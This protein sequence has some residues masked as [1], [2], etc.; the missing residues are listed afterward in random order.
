MITE[1]LK[2]F[3]QYEDDRTHGRPVWQDRGFLGL[4]V[5]FLAALAAKYAGVELDSEMQAALVVV[6][7]G[8]FHLSQPHVGLVKKPEAD[9]SPPIVPAT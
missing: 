3:Y 8:I 4:I 9:G 6:V 1:I 7:A 5:G 2:I